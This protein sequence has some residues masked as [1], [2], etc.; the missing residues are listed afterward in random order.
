VNPYRANRPVFDASAVLALMPGE[1]GSERLKNLQAA[2]VVNA[3]NAAEVLAELVS[4]GVPPGEAQAAYDALPLETTAFEPLMAAVSARY[5]SKGVS[6]GDRCFLAA[7]HRHGSRP[8][9][10]RS[11]IWGRYLE[12]RVP[13]LNFF[14]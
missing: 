8:D 5:V 3:V 9:G 2:A 13:P 4:R 11:E 6:L 7:T 14:R 10:L 1:P 12:S